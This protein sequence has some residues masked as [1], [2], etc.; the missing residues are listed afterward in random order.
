MPP[1][2]QPWTLFGEKHEVCPL[3]KAPPYWGEL[4]SLYLAKEQ[5]HLPWAGGLMDQPAWFPGVMA[6][7]GGSMAE[8][9]E[10]AAPDNVEV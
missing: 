1:G 8:S 4:W 7:I 6:Y 2:R 3:P 10:D 9:Y 5:G